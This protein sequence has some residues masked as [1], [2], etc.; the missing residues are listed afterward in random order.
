VLGRRQTLAVLVACTALK[1][2]VAAAVVGTVE[3]RQMR[4]QAE[5]MVAGRDVLDPASTGSNPSFFLSGH[6]ALVTGAWALAAASGL[7]FSFLI[8]LPAIVADLVTSGLLLSAGPALARGARGET[9]ALAYMLNPVTLLLSAYHGQPHSV[10]VAGAVLALWMVPRGAVAG[11]GAVLAMAASVRQH[12]AVVAVPLALTLPG[13]RRWRFLGAAV[14][15]GLALNLGLIASAHPGRVLAPTWVYGA[16]GYGLLLQQGPRL[17]KRLGL[18]SGETVA[19]SLTELI[20]Q[21][22]WLVFFAWTALFVAA[23]L[24]AERRGAPLDPWRATL[25]FLAGLC[26]LSPGFGVQWAVWVLPFWLVVD[27]RSGLVYS[28]VAGAFLAGSYWQW[29]LPRRY[30][31]ES[32]TAHLDLLSRV[33]LVGMVAVAGLSLAT[34]ALMIWAAW[35]FARTAP[36]NDAR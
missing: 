35:H 33:E 13:P 12:F 15:T 25:V 17:L 6:Y 34:W 5:A 29:T 21:Y 16:W 26:A 11:A 32:I 31:V 23:C 18:P 30:G 1:V 20:L 19:G 8:K 9:L 14:A 7:P 22:G 10:A 3:V 27:L 4:Q 24:R 36:G 2:A 28:W